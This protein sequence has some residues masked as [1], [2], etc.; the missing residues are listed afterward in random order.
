[1]PYKPGLTNQIIRQMAEKEALVYFALALIAAAG[2][3]LIGERVFVGE[4]V[5]TDE[6]SYIY[7]AWL[8]SQGKLRLSC[9]QL[10]D[11]FFH[12]MIICDDQ[13]GWVSRYPPVQILWLVPGV[14]LGHP[15]LMTAVAAFLAVWFLIKAG[16]RLDIPGWCTVLL[17]MISP[18]FWLMQG[19]VLSHTSAL[20]ATAVMIWAYLVWIQ[21]HKISFTVIAGLAWAF[22]F[23]GRSYTAI[24]IAL[25]FAVDALIRLSQTRTRR[26]LIGTLSFAVSASTG[27]IAY[28]AY[29]YLITGD[30]L[31]STFLYYNLSDGLGFGFRHDSLFTPELGWGYIKTNV[32]ALNVNLWG[33]KG[34]LLLWLALSLYGW[35]KRVS[36]MFFAIIFLVWLAYGAFWFRGIT[37][38][39]P[40]YYYET[41]AFMV[42][43]AGMGL[44]RLFRLNWRVPERMKH[45]LAG[46]LIVTISFSALK[47]FNANAE[48]VNKRLSY[49]HGKNLAIQSVPPGAIVIL[50]K[51]QK[52]GVAWNPRGLVSDPITVRDVYGVSLV[53]PRLF[54]DRTLYQ[55]SANSSAKIRRLQDWEH[56]L[57]VIP[58]T[59]TRAKTGKRIQSVSSEN[60]IALE[61][62]HK[63]GL[64]AYTVRQYMLP[65]LYEITYILKASGAPGDKIG[66]IDLYD[67]QQGEILQTRNL[68]P[69][70]RS[71]VFRL[72]V[73]EDR[74]V[75][76]L[77]YFDGAGQL[78]FDRIEIR[79]LQAEPEQQQSS[80]L[81]VGISPLLL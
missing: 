30:A 10:T 33:F 17:L 75:E 78:E 58:A 23:L 3:L 57:R 63:A 62:E 7:Q 28:L 31:Q 13:V 27:V 16:K 29:N 40:I 4:Y 55:L 67:P 45:L 21:E 66:H 11:A 1:M 8:F 44:S 20:A 46:L 74:I 26:E 52:W 60:Y 54:P 71:V 49:I 51:S 24:W 73:Y 80:L 42:L 41:L 76:P 48:V 81:P 12:R 37:D 79:L 56:V 19:T 18:Y 36:T 14:V 22:L 35:R 61:S 32:S 15:R 38:I 50:D 43:A 65:G 9:P 70:D 53:L 6:H 5:T 59:S 72:N 64:L 77:L 25:P 34:S 2:A 68:M 69:G 47:T 39:Q